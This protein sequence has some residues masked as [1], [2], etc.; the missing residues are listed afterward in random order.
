M[1]TFAACWFAFALF[2]VATGCGDANDTGHPPSIVGDDDDAGSPFCVDADEDGY[3]KRC[4]RGSDCDDNDPN[5]TDE[6][7]RCLTPT[8]GCSC[9]PGRAAV[10]CKPPD[11]PGDG[12]IL[13]CEEGSRYCRNGIWSDCETIGGYVFQAR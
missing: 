11:L 6:C 8:M 4:N 3:G 2:A 1:R 9:E 5:V 7:R 13:V 12:G 10:G